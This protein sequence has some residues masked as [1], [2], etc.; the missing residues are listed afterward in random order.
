MTKRPTTRLEKGLGY[1]Y[2]LF[3]GV[4]AGLSGTWALNKPV[5]DL[6]PLV[7]LVFAISLAGA[8][9]GFMTTRRRTDPLWFAAVWIC[10]LLGLVVDIVTVFLAMK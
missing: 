8:V 2:V 6:G 3:N 4:F 5:H 7:W 1:F 9:S 10:T